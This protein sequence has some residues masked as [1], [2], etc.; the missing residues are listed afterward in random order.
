MGK[1]K[2]IYNSKRWQ[3]L[4][5]QKL[6]DEPFCEYC[7]ASRRLPAS[8]VDHYIAI[9]NGGDPYDYDNLRSVCHSCH[10]KKTASGERVKGCDKN[11]LPLD[12]THPWV[13]L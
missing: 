1:H 10:S 2:A 4:R 13:A 8:E 12:P 11:G 6:R 9:S 5:A 3:R 7:P